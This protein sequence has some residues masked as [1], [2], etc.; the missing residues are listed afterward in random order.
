MTEPIA[1]VES[2]EG[3]K[4]QFI[5]LLAAS[6][7]PLTPGTAYWVV[8]KATSN[9][10]NWYYATS[11]T[12]EVNGGTIGG[13][14]VPTDGSTWTATSAGVGFMTVG[15]CTPLPSC[16]ALS[17]LGQSGTAQVI[18]TPDKGGITHLA[19]KFEFY[20]GRATTIVN[21]TLPLLLNATGPTV[22]AAIFSVIF[23]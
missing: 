21:I 10:Y 12:Q 13:I 3:Y 16:E 14:A 7:V 5:T 11:D 4:Y 23:P 8:A 19:S 15:M 17:N 1:G 6:F 18:N 22:Q 2:N 9:S 20:S